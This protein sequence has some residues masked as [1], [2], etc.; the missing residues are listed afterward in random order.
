MK[1]ALVCI[2][3]MLAGGC[4]SSRPRA[5]GA[6]RSSKPDC[7][8]ITVQHG[9]SIVWDGWLMSVRD[10]S[11]AVKEY[12]VHCAVIKAAS[13]AAVHYEAALKVRDALSAA[14]VKDVRVSSGGLRGK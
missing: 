2:A 1:L 11:T 12:D 7:V 14:G 9:E 13:G 8:V 10:I 4:A 5:G 3:M 6:D